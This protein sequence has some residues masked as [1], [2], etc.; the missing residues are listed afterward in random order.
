MNEI[1]ELQ[2]ARGRIRELE[3]AGAVSG[4]RR[5]LRGGSRSSGAQFLRSP[6]RTSGI[7]ARRINGY[8]FRL[9]RSVSS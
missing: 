3:A 5:I 7:P 9:A 2:A 1:D 6:F 4:S 8:G